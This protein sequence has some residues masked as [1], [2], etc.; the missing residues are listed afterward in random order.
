MWTS[1]DCC[2]LCLQNHP[3]STNTADMWT[4]PDC[5]ALCQQIT[6]KVQT[7]QD[8]WTSPDCSILCLQNH[9]EDTT[10]WRRSH[11]LLCLYFQGDFVDRG[12]YSLETFTYLAVFVLWGW[13]CRQR[14]Q[15]SRDV[16]ISAVFVLWGWFCRQR[17]QQSRDVHISAV[18][19]LSGWFCRQRV[20]QS[21]DIHLPPVFEGAMAGQDHVT[22]RE[23]REQT[24]H[25]SLRLL[26]SVNF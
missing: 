4:S 1:L 20:L 7:Q 19:V 8:M 2:T 23:P 24:N 21:R 18:F 17:V 22:T 9:P 14:V 12:Y 3:Q 10:V 13:F 15:R 16:H 25:T 5:S 6:L 26:W 11:I